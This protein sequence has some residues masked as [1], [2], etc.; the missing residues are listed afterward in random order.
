[1]RALWA[2][3]DGRTDTV[4]ATTTLPQFPAYE[5]SASE[6]VDLIATRT[7]AV[8]DTIRSVRDAVD[9]KT[10]PAPTSCTG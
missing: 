6:V 7:Y 5:Q 3:P 2:V 10:L 4:A 9:P 8:V 1:M